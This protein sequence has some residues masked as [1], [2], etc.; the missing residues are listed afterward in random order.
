MGLPQG[1][2]LNFFRA[3][4]LGYPHPLLKRKGRDFSWT[5]GMSPSKFIKSEKLSIVVRRLILSHLSLSGLFKSL[6]LL[7][8][9][10]NILRCTCEEERDC[11]ISGLEKGQLP[12]RVH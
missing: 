3:H 5:N 12:T 10:E 4:S 8:H 9:I 11:S 2:P 1:R 7:D 6:T